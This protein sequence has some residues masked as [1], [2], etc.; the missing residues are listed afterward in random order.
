M[1]N[2]AFFEDHPI[3]IKSLETIFSSDLRFSIK[4]MVSTK[5]D[6]FE[7]LNLNN[8]IDVLVL[9]L[10]AADVQGTELFDFVLKMHPKIKIIAFTSISSATLV[11]NLLGI[12]VKGYVNKKEPIEHLSEAIIKVHNDKISLPDDYAFL[13]RVTIEPKQV[14][15]SKRE[16]EVLNLIVNGFTTN[17]IALKLSITVST[18]ESHRA[19]ISTKLNVKNLA[20]MIREAAKLGYISE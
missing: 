8:D 9:D 16:I 18:I 13:R 2:I 12:G 5:N 19:K 1:I 7:T 3:V 15:L 17:E 20:G 4:F 14:L 11:E 6:L 10:L